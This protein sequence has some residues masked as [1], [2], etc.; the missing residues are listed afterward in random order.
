MGAA[1]FL[2]HTYVSLHCLDTNKEIADHFIRSSSI[3]TMRL[4]IVHTHF[5]TSSVANY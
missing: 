1:S 2:F 3:Q 5:S 4:K